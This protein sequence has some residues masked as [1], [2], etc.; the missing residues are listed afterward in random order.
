[1]GDDDWFILVNSIELDDKSITQVLL[2]IPLILLPAIVPYEYYVNLI[3]D[4]YNNILI[5]P[6]DDNYDGN[7]II[8]KYYVNLF[9]ILFVGIIFIIFT[10]VGA[11][12]IVVVP[13]IF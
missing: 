5:I 2:T 11:A 8:N 3:D 9:T 4:K 12:D 1:M 6:N 10:V 13:I 7:S